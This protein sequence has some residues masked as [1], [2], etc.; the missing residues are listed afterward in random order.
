MNSIGA[1]IKMLRT[2][3]GLSQEQLGAMIGKTRSAV[4][5]YE[6]GKAVPRMGVI[7]GIAKVFGVKKSAIIE[8]ITTPSTPD[9]RNRLTERERELIAAFRALDETGKAAVVQLAHTLSRRADKQG[10]AEE[11]M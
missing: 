1:N 10:D 5:Q 11:V 6:S 8:G 4:S 9:M 3:A 7:E 2:S